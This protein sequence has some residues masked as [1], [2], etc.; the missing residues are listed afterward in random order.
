MSNECYHLAHAVA[1]ICSMIA[2]D[3]VSFGI[4]ALNMAIVQKTLPPL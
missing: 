1:L 4:I 2:N 3:A